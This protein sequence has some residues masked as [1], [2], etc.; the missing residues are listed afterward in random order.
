[1]LHRVC[2]G[3]SSGSSV[4]CLACG[5]RKQ[6]RESSFALIGGCETGED[7]MPIAK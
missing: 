4:R 7:A 2:E 6:K 5:I 1:M 3:G